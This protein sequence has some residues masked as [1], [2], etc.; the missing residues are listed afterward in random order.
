[1]EYLVTSGHIA[2]LIVGLV[3][4]EAIVLIA[5]RQH[6]GHGVPPFDLIVNLASGACLVLALRSAL[7]HAWWGWTAAWLAAALGAHLADLRRRWRR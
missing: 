5:Y 2:D 7:T 4:L 3:I 6:S 1:M